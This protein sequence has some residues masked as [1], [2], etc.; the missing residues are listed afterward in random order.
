MTQQSNRGF[1]ERIPASVFSADRPASCSHAWLVRNNLLHLRDVFTQVR[2]YRDLEVTAPSVASYLVPHN[3]PN[4]PNAV[5]FGIPFWHTWYAENVPSN[6]Y[7]LTRVLLFGSAM[8]GT[9]RQRVVPFFHAGT[10]LQTTVGDLSV[11]ALLDESASAIGAE[12]FAVGGAYHFDEQDVRQLGIAPTAVHGHL[13]EAGEPA[14]YEVYKMRLDIR[15]TGASQ[16]NL[17]DILW[18]VREFA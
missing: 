2:A 16:P 1:Y 17:E 10:S 4:D 11:P 8:D 9:I 18:Y 15:F 7:V 13:L 5:V 14:A 6:L 3:D 12:E